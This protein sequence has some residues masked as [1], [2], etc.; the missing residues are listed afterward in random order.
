MKYSN[1]RIWPPLGRL[2]DALISLADVAWTE[3]HAPPASAQLALPP[4]RLHLM[5]AQL[6]AAVA[7]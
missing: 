3:A 4:T 2:A 1:R 5:A 7:V 6:R